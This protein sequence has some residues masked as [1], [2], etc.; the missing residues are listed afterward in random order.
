MKL[1]PV[2]HRCDTQT[3]DILISLGPH[4]HQSN[5][6][7]VHLK[8]Q[9][10]SPNVT[11]P[12]K[13]SSATAAFK[14]RAGVICTNSDL[15]SLIS[16]LASSATEINRYDD[17]SPAHTPT[18]ATK[19]KA[20]LTPERRSSIKTNRSNSFDVSI[21]KNIKQ[22]IT[23]G[24]TSSPAGEKK[25]ISIPTGW[26]TKR[27][28]PMAAKKGTA[29]TT[30]ASTPST[31]KPQHPTVTFAKEALDKFRDKES[32]SNNSSSTKDAK[33]GAKKP[34]K[35][36]LSKLKWDGR[37]A[38]VDARMI[39]SAIEGFLRR[40]SNPSSPT[41][42]SSSGNK[43]NSKSRKKSTSWFGKSDDSDSGDTCE[44]SLCSTLKD[45]FVK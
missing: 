30:A 19:P 1:V 29:A 5:H 22:H 12:S 6:S 20:S 8:I 16:S 33:D 43:S 15:I 3:E 13:L 9:I 18:S 28:Q 17:K 2:H 23:P 42:S 39:G 34:S 37:S 7:D 14:Q 41:A 32:N 26:F 25:L 10:W 36:P 31:T 44:S 45:L 35:S 4:C 40:D 11:T 38:M 24:S 27:H 21:L